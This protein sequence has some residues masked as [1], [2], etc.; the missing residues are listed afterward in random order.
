VKAI[1]I[2][3]FGP[4][5]VMKWEEVP[6]PRPG[7][8]QVV[9]RIGAVG[10]NPVETYIRSGAYARLPVPP[11]TPGND[12]AGLVEAVGE[13]V[14]RVKA[15][16]RVFLTGTISG[17]YAEKALCLETQVHPL[18]EKISFAQGAGV[19]TPCSA[20]YR[21]LFQ[22]A[23]AIPGEI[24]MVHGATGGVGIAAIQMAKAAGLR[25]I[26]TG[27]TDKGRLLIA[28][29]GAHQVLD[30][31]A[32]GYLEKALALTGGRGI[33]VIVELLAN[34]NLGKDLTVLAQGGR[35]VVIG[36]RGPVEINPRDA[37]ARDGAIL[38]ML[39][40]NA[41]ERE[42]RS[43]HAALVAGLENGTLR[44]VVGQEFPLREAARAHRRILE[45]GALGK[46]VLI[47]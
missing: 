7:V 6:D 37:M 19:N 27:G 34:V 10:V 46:I 14:E 47:P 28:E 36:S 18:S 32:A 25:V 1:R 40:T 16:D 5:E 22:R 15:G 42:T 33:D 2:H 41:S 13:G 23:K 38:G 11:F 3:E 29:Q 39:V 24:V 9:V 8:Q 31:H 4:P 44:P 12:A 21:A 30:H 43:I 45:P 20:A 35:V 26:G 17:A